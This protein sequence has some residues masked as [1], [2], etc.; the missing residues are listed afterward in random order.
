MAAKQ[1]K[2]VSA[3]DDG[4]SCVERKKLTGVEETFL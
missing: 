3:S 1:Q 4:Y 2:P